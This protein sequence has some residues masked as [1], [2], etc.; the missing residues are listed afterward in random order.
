M[1][2]LFTVISVVLSVA[3]VILSMI[4]IRRVAC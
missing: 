3:A 2:A 1:K 4:S